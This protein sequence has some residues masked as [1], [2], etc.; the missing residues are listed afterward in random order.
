MDRGVRI[1]PHA[2]QQDL[3]VEIMNSSDGAF[4]AMWRDGERIAGDSRGFRARGGE[5][6]AMSA[7]PDAGQPPKGVRDDAKARGCAGRRWIKDGRVVVSPG[8]HD[9]RPFHAYSG[10]QSVDQSARATLDRSH[11]AK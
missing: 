8:W 7:P 9:D 1:V 4:L 5:R 2:E 10:S 6:E 11:C 3:S